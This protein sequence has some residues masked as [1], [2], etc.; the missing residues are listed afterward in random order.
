MAWRPESGDREK[1]Q[2]MPADNIKW[3]SWLRVARGYQLRIG[4]KDRSR[5]TF[6]GFE[7]EVRVPS[8]GVWPLS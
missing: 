2:N 1:D 3:A 8:L 6:D 5:E 4:L 7:R